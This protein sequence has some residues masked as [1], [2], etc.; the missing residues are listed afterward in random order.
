MDLHHRTVEARTGVIAFLSGIWLIVAPIVLDFQAQATGFRP[1]WQAMAVAVFIMVVGVVRALAPLDLPGL[2]VLTLV[3]AL[4]LGFA[5]LLSDSDGNFPVLA[6]QVVVA[7]VVV[8]ST[9]VSALL[10]RLRSP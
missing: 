1:Y 2:D 4:W 3:P 8:V 7:A 5:P 6:N 9:V 10:I